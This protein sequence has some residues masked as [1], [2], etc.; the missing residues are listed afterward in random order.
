MTTEIAVFKQVGEIVQIAY[1]VSDLDQ[2]IAH[3]NSLGAGPFFVLRKIQYTEHLYQGTHTDCEV[4]AAFG[5]LG[6]MQI[7]LL[8]QLNDAPSLLK[9]FV[10][11]QGPGMQHLGILSK[12]YD[13]DVAQLEADGF[14]VLQRM[15]ST[16]GARTALFDTGVNGASVLELIEETEATTEAFAI[17]KA[18]ATDWDASKPGAIDVEAH[19][20]TTN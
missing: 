17:M 8:Q 9:D 10:D 16:T 6:N 20:A 14:T 1:A 13:Q 12:T 7:E 2:A 19:A 15:V 11:T 4:A 18:A 5:Y 3:W